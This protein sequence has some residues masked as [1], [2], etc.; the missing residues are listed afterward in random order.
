MRSIV[1]FIISVALLMATYTALVRCID[2]RM[3]FGSHLFPPVAMNT[4][5]ARMELFKTYQEHGRIDGLILG[6]SRSMQ[7]QPEAFH[8]HFGGRFFNFSVT[9]GKTE[10]FLAIYRWALARGEHPRIVVIGLDVESL[11][12]A[13]LPDDELLV[14]PPLRN[15]LDNEGVASLG[16]TPRFWAPLQ[17]W[18]DT[19]TSS[20]LLDSLRSVN[21]L[22][23]PRSSDLES[24]PDGHRYYRF[25]D[26]QRAAGTF[27][28]DQEVQ[29]TL[30]AALY[31]FRTMRSLSPKRTAYLE[32]TLQL[33]R[34]DRA[35]ALVFLTTYH[36]LIMEYCRSSPQIWRRWQDIRAYLARL[37]SLPGVHA[38]DFSEQS[39]YG[40]RI[41][42]WYD[43]LHIDDTN[44]SRLVARMFRDE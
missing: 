23:H 19:L 10:D 35:H 9:S 21:Y 13:L 4:R 27:D 39:F 24:Y 20:Y 28:L 7:L 8:A 32:Q 33:A 16:A 25:S 37:R 11:S 5:I 36:P 44:A 1:V 43:A 14:T 29:K 22:F 26:A 30:P 2:P 3:K 6:S 15:M 41:E 42:N 38:Y 34:A 18:N 40:G 17:E 12:D 31:L